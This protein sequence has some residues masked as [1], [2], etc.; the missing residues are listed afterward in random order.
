MANGCGCQTGI[1]RWVKPPYA[2]FFYAACCIHDDDYDRGGNEND[3]KNADLR[4]YMN[5]FRK[6]AKAGFA[7]AKTW[8]LTNVAMLYYCSVRL[9]GSNYFNY[10]R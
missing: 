6:I 1:F 3:R 10:C 5:C 8:W 9:M 4:L 7:P 2:S